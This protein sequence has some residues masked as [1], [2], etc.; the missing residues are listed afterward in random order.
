MYFSSS[1][2]KNSEVTSPTEWHLDMPYWKGT[3]DK[4]A[5]WIALNK[6][7]RENGCLKYIARSHNKNYVLEDS[8]HGGMYKKGCINPNHIDKSDEVFVELEV[9]DVSLHHRNIVHGSE[10]NTLKKEQNVLI[11]VYQPGSD[12]SNHRDGPGVPILKDI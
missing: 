1:I 11:F 9:G 7:T 6:V 5:V 2:F 8:E 3:T 10:E 12:T 4:T